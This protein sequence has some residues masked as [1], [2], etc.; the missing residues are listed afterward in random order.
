MRQMIESEDD[1]KEEIENKKEKGQIN[2]KVES[3]RF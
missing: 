2:E 1:L 3:L